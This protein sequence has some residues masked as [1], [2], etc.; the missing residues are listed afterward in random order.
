MEAGL[1]VGYAFCDNF[2][3]LLILTTLVAFFNSAPFSFIEGYV[4]PLAK[5][6]K[7]SYSFI[8]M[9]GTIGYIVALL[10]G[11]LL[12]NFISIRDCLFISCSLFALSSVASF[13]LL[14]HEEQ[15]FENAGDVDAFSP[16]LLSKSF[17][18]YVLFAFFFL[19][20]FNAMG[21]I[22]PLRLTALEMSDSAY[23]LSRG[24]GI[25]GELVCLLL[26][27]LFAKHL[28]TFKI[29][30]IIS[31]SLILLSSSVGIFLDNPFALG[32]SSFILSGSGKAFR[33][34]FEPL[35]LILIV[36]DKNLPKA[37]VILSGAANLTSA[38]L[39]LFSDFLYV[40]WG[41]AGY[42]V[43]ITVLQTIG[44]LFLLLAKEK[45][46]PVRPNAIPS[47]DKE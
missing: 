11:S 44:F 18:F 47:G 6:N 21:Y 4:V 24:V 42:F 15:Q 14:E 46:V 31:A 10:L 5:Q 3:S 28:Q 32:Y 19:G 2:V 9:F 38:L 17:I 36:G 7:T 26:I 33:F 43:F 25:C 22:L 45:E 20:A 8:R 37:L 13:F 35:F 40:S 34:A 23:S 1:I 29:P 12:L 16:P 30:L 27:P 39:N 41:F